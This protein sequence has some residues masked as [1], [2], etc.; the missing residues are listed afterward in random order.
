MKKTKKVL[1]A[2]FDY[3]HF[4][5]NEQLEKFLIRASQ[6]NE[7]QNFFVQ[8]DSSKTFTSERFP[9]NE[10]N[11]VAGGESQQRPHPNPDSG[12]EPTNYLEC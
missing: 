12:D 8:K 11:A 1:Y 4:S 5:H 3:Q 2:L 9:L 6:I 10:L 7:V